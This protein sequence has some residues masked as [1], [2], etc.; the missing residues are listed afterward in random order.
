MKKRII[1]LSLVLF[2][3]LGFLPVGILTA[4][5]TEPGTDMDA[6]TALGIDTGAAPDGYDPYSTD[7]P[8][9][10]DTVVMAPVY[11]LYQVGLN[12]IVSGSATYPTSGAIQNGE[13]DDAA[14]SAS[15]S[16]TLNAT[17]YG[18]ETWNLTTASGILNAGVTTPVAS[19]TTAAQGAYTLI[20]SGNITDTAASNIPAV[21]YLK[22]AVNASTDLGGGFAY[23]LSSV[24]AGNFDSNENGLSAQTVMVYTT[25]YSKNGGLYLRFGNAVTGTYGASAKEILPTVKDI[26]NP[27]L[28]YEGKPV[29]NFAEAP[30]QLQNYLQVTT[31]DWNGDG[32]DEVAVY[33]PEAGNSRIVVYA[34]QLTS[35]DDR[36]TAY[37][38]PAKWSV[39]WTYYLREGDVVSNMVS[40][41]S[42]DVNEDGIDDLAGT[43]GY[44]YGPTQ[45][46][47]STA[48]VMFGAKGTAMLN[49]SQ[50]FDLTYGSSNIVRASF[51]F[52]D[53]AGSNQDVLVLCGQSDA[54]LKAGNTQTRYVALYSWNG[55]AFATNVYQNFDLFASVHR[56]H[57]LDSPGGYGRRGP[58]VF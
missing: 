7:N 19:G 27:A 21:G 22:D 2:L 50:Q 38:N 48:V 28:T 56:Q 43:W 51:D 35:Q 20:S 12:S 5:A 15:Y 9:G 10:R 33:I 45:N 47:G 14:Y 58:A 54:D 16:N 6:L 26:G 29:E 46:L 57:R 39:V 18:N 24:A 11:E 8:Y 31:G 36:S 53:M 13:T 49:T 4:S 55:T 17:L 34:L 1:S 23:A 42:G 30:Y 37:L 40:L 52:G 3:L 44:Y 32:L 41:V 25:D